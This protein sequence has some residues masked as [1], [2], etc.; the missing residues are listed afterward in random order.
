MSEIPPRAFSAP[1]GG[2][3]AESSYLNRDEACAK[4]RALFA[5]KEISLAIFKD[6]RDAESKTLPGYSEDE[7][8]TDVALAA[9]L[10]G[11]YEA[12]DDDSK[13][14]SDILE[15]VIFKCGK[16]NLWFGANSTAIKTAP[17][18]DFVNH[19]DLVV[20]TEVAD[21]EYS[22]LALG[23]D[24]TF[25]G[26]LREKFNKIRTAIDKGELGHV[27]Y[28]LS[29]RP[30]PNH[31]DLEEPMKFAGP[32]TNIPWVVV[33]IEIARAKELGL[34]WMNNKN[35]QLGK[36]P[37]QR[38]ILRQIALELKTFAGYARRI[39]RENLAVI[40][41]TQLKKVEEIMGE[42]RAAGIKVI[43]SDRVF[44]EIKNN[45]AAF[46]APN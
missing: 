21:Q 38:M 34:L 27:K 31:P 6:L 15:A 5:E 40:L 2:K 30:D 1:A 11:K 33:G 41:E 42:K 25:S 35:T 9:R 19:V 23:V 10:R 14:Y 36:H 45:L 24:V 16:D 32:L 46:E 44:E 20:E 43:E 18:D 26:D 37:A 12:S 28:F 4:A 13:K 3:A 22:H 29:D 17:F 39:G 8:R 7:I